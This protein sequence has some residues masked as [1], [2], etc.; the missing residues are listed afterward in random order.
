MRRYQIAFD[1]NSPFVFD[2]VRLSTVCGWQSPPDAPGAETYVVAHLFRTVLGRYVVTREWSPDAA[3]TAV[4]HLLASETIAGL[5]LRL[6]DENGIAFHTAPFLGTVDGDLL[7]LAGFGPPP[8]DLHALWSERVA[9]RERL[10]AIVLELSEACRRKDVGAVT[11]LDAERTALV[12]RLRVV[13][14]DLEELA[15]RWLESE[16]VGVAV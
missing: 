10:A 8:G 14:R 15:V 2:G 4:R 16:Y 13:E 6:M 5:V 9:A 7:R 12:E 1:G 11:R 3:S